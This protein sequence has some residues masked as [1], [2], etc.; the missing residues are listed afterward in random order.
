MV[1]AAA[2][3]SGQKDPVPPGWIGGLRGAHL[4]RVH[5]PKQ[6][7]LEKVLVV[8]SALETKRGK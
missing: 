4:P 1:H 7:M 8:D 3:A 5:T 2:K 6:A